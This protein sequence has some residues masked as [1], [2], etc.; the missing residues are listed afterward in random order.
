MSSVSRRGFLAAL[1]ASGIA[2]LG[3]A[4]DRTRATGVARRN[5]ESL[6]S[7][8]FESRDELAAFVDERMRGRIGD[9]T[10]GASVAVVVEGGPSLVA[11]YGSANVE[12]GVPAR[13]DETPFRIGSVGKLITWTA[14]MQGVERGVL[15]LDE[16]VN[17]Y[18][19]D[20]AVTV[21]E[22]DDDPVTLRH[23]GT[24]TAGFASALDPGIVAEPD[25]L[26]PLETLLAEERPDRVRPPGAL[27]GYSNYGA[28]LA[29]H[30][31]AEAHGTTF[32]E[33]VQSEVF[34]PL[35]MS[36]STFAQ[37]VPE[38]HP[39]DPAAGH[40][41]DGTGFTTADET[42]VNMRPAGS[43][44]AT[45]SDVAAFVRAHLG[46]GAV[47][48]GR[49]LNPE[50]VEA[51][52]DRHHVRHPAVT[53]WRYG[54]HEYGGPDAGLVGHSGATVDFASR[55]V[56][57][58]D[59]GVGV[60]V[61]YNARAGESPAAVVDEIL[62]AFDLLPSPARAP[63]AKP[64]GRARAETVAGEYS[65]TNLP[66]AGPLHVADVLAHVAVEPAGDG[67]LR[68][69]TAGGDAREWVETEPYVY[70]AVD[71]R[72]VLAFE[73]DD[74]AVT[75]MNANSDPTGV[76]LPVP[77]HERRLLTGSVVGG[78]AAGFGLSLAGRVGCRVRRGWRRV[79]GARRDGGESDSGGRNDA[80]SDG[81]GRDGTE[82][83]RR[84]R[85][86]TEADG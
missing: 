57:S 51:M 2:G 71:G 64:G 21:P 4:S 16:D 58:R 47:D 22:T 26:A 43:T 85:N 13:G 29:G 17:A 81:R 83:D 65:P 14:V 35:D 79:R 72:D 76:H 15:S 49:V 53:N 46:D 54:F 56:L 37:P 52:H 6:G 28:A 38:D 20:S 44:T 7:A 19:D 59:R 33:Y 75:A 70:R 23:L 8:P 27:V 42:F 45:A 78:T 80:E 55:L 1:G 39:G 86:D 10:P 74:G 5:A 34:E 84:D 69:T 30:V 63:S 31:V 68:T 73:V 25:A 32:E 3:L 9:A 66:N 60:F 61:N 24:H 12:A 77:F 18:L 11:G 62:A 40:E 82:T 41:R 67:R 36:H 48:G 50:T